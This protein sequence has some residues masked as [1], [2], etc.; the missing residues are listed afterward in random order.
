MVSSS[1]ITI[2]L[3][4][5]PSSLLPITQYLARVGAA[6]ATAL[7]YRLMSSDLVSSPGVP[8]MCPKN[9]SGVGTLLDAGRWST[10]SVVIRGSVRYSLIFAVYSASCFCGAAAAAACA[11]ARLGTLIAIASPAIADKRRNPGW[12]IVPPNGGLGLGC[13]INAYA[14]VRQGARPSKTKSGRGLGG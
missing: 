12:D 2:T 11:R 7:R 5:R 3:I 1:P 4:S 13:S 6:S 10:S 8:T 14:P 9:F